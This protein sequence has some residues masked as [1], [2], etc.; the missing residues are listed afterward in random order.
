M[1][2]I[3]PQKRPGETSEKKYKKP[4]NSKQ[5]LEVLIQATAEPQRVPN[6]SSVDTGF[7]DVRTIT[8]KHRLTEWVISHTFY[9]LIMSRLMHITPMTSV[10]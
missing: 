5:R 1:S 10:L 8:E 2:T 4:K 6:A 9:S 3:N 7:R